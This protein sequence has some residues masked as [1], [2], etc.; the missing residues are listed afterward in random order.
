MFFLVPLLYV[1]LLLGFG[2][3]RVSL[4]LNELLPLLLQL[5]LLP[6]RILTD[7]LLLLS[8]CVEPRHQAVDGTFPVGRNNGNLAPEVV[9]PFLGIELRLRLE[10]ERAFK[11]LWNLQRVES[12]LGPD[13]LLTILAVPLVWH[14][15]SCLGAQLPDQLR[16]PPLGHVDH[17]VIELLRLH[18]DPA[19]A[20]HQVREQ[21]AILEGRA[22]V[23][24][25]ALG[26]LDLAADPAHRLDLRASV[27]AH[28]EVGSEHVTDERGVPENLV[29]LANKLQLLHDVEVGGRL[30]H[31][32]CRADAVVVHLLPAPEGEHTRVRGDCG[33]VVRHGAVGV[34]QG[35]LQEPHA[36]LASVFE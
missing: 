6:A 21:D 3:V 19:L 12:A 16:W 9:F 5:L 30:E 33:T 34:L 20:D 36:L 23:T 22:E 29:R 24:L 25:V 27:L 18:A 28:F 10:G 35:V 31:H 14:K 13:E 17:G 4:V 7:S 26:L 15:N 11:R 1:P 2:G 32:G 8:H